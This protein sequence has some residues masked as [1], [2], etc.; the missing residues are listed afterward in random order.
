MLQ[1]NYSRLAQRTFLTHFRR[2]NCQVFRQPSVAVW[3]RMNARCT[4]L[5]RWRQ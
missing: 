4:L 1:T 2:S 5:L 3:S